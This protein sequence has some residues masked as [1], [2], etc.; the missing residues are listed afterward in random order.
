MAN[1]SNQRPFEK[2]R[3]KPDCPCNCSSKCIRTPIHRGI[4]GTIRSP[5]SLSQ[6]PMDNPSEWMTP[7]APQFSFKT[8]C[9]HPLSST[10]PLFWPIIFDI[11][12]AAAPGKSSAIDVKRMFLDCVIGRR[13]IGNTASSLWPCQKHSLNVYII[14]ESFGLRYR[15][16]RYSQYSFLLTISRTVTKNLILN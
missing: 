10:T 14:G 6:K 2:Q 3:K 16:S 13:G 12:R 9:L 7:A 15:S 11:G 4:Q 5:L 8:N 1:P